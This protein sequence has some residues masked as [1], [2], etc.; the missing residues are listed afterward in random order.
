MLR[1]S[2]YSI[3]S[4]PLHGGGYMLMNGISG[5]VDFVTQELGDQLR[6]AVW[7][8]RAEDA[9]HVVSA[10]DLQT[11]RDLQE[12]GHLTTLSLDQERNTVITLADAFHH[13][14]QKRPSFMIVPNLDCNYRCTYCFERPLQKG[15]S[16]SRAE[17]SHVRRN[18]VLTP[19]QIPAIY[20]VI[21][22]LQVAAGQPKGGQ[23]ILYGG[24]PL[25]GA[26]SDIVRAIVVQ[27]QQQGHFF[28]AVTNGHDLDQYLDLVGS[29]GIEQVQISIDGP[30]RVHDKRRIYLGKGSSFDKLVENI[31]KVL[32][33][34]DAQVQLRVHVDPKNI[35]SFEETLVFF[36]ERGW[37][38]TPRVVIYAN[39]VYEKSKAGLV[40]TGLEVGEVAARLSEHVR[41]HTNVFAG[42]PEIHAMRALR[43]AFE[44]GTRYQLKAT[45]CTANTGNYIF[46]P[47]GR[48]YA[49]WES[50]GKA[51]SRVGSYQ[52]D[53]TC[54]LDPAAVQK[55]FG[56]SIAKLPIC[57]RCPY[58][59]VCGGGCAQYA[60]Y[61]AGDIYRPYCD[62]FQRSFREALRNTSDF[63]LRSSGPAE[64]ESQVRRSV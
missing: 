7:D 14:Q 58:A 49:C 13:E 64:V 41:R 51:C 62:D 40:E 37:T 38:D 22:N 32:S 20:A 42:A 29:G 61:N 45:Y 9:A 60:E 25:D 17:I 3:L 57:Q 12:R 47:D 1:F 18:V 26:H 10:L 21:R 54:N 11:C 23:I 31:A 48:I 56:R 33:C 28:A 43:P 35:G 4:A 36:E 6:D 52:V 34:T 19:E 63:Y 39:T 30:K 16:G 2:H 50:I 53:G 27:G 46:A 55:W 44:E 24:E 15:L 5:A 8:E 59:L